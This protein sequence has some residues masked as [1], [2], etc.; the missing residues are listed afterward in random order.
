MRSMRAEGK[1][2]VM[3]REKIRK[4]GSVIGT[5]FAVTCLIIQF[6]D[7]NVVQS[8]WIYLL[9]YLGIYH[10]FKSRVIDSGEEL[11]GSRVFCILAFLLSFTVITGIYF[12]HGLPFEEMTAGIFGMYVICVIGFMPL[13]RYAFVVLFRVVGAD[14]HKE[15]NHDKRR[16]GK[17]I[18]GGGICRYTGLLDVSLAGLLSGTVEL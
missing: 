3:E 6:S 18:G 5:L 14:M 8:S 7:A 10:I 15:Q 12:D 9:A 17:K 2:R 11:F 4:A 1:D 16:S 13:C